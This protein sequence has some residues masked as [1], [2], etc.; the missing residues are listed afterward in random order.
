MHIGPLEALM[1]VVP[2]LSFLGFL[3]LLA[4]QC[5]KRNASK[6]VGPG[7]WGTYE[8]KPPAA[9]VVDTIHCPPVHGDKMGSLAGNMK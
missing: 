2:M 1:L 3:G 5:V 9:V 4:G 6:D 7:Y 8:S